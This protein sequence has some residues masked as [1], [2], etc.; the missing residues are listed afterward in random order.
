MFG[1]LHN[2]DDS[3]LLD[4]VKIILARPSVMTAHD[5]TELQQI[6]AEFRRREQEERNTKA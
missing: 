1:D 5:D 6:D 3:T 2:T 4:F